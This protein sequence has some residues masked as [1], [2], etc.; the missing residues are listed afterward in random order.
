MS[1]SRSAFL[2]RVTAP[3]VL[4]PA[5]VVGFWPVWRWYVAR[6]S[7]GSDEPLGLLALVAAVVFLPRQGWQ[8]GRSALWLGT[9][10]ATLAVYVATLAIAP[11]LIR[12]AL[13][14][15]VVVCVLPTERGRSRAPLFSLLLLSLPVIASLQYYL[16]YPLR[17]LTAWCCAHV[18]GVAGLAVESRGTVLTWTG[19]D[20]LLDAP[21]SGIR[22]LWMAAFLSATLAAGQ[23][24]GAWSCVRLLQISAALVFVANLAR[25]VVLFFLET[26]LWPNPA[27]AHEAVG[28]AAFALVV[29]GCW[30][31]SRRLRKPAARC[32][33][34]HDVVGFPAGVAG[35]VLVLLA[36]VAAARPAWAVAAAPATVA[37]N[38][39]W[40]ASFEERPLEPATLHPFERK[41]AR[42]FPGAIAAFT[43]GER[44]IVFRQIQQATRK[45]HPIADC[46]RASGFTVRAVAAQRDQDGNLWAALEARGP[47][48]KLA[49]RER[50]TDSRGHAWT[51]ASAWYWAAL[52]HPRD[53]PWLSVTVLAPT[54]RR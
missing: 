13:A 49:V 28:L 21:C 25:S 43:D 8:T 37:S 5:L 35:V 48:T 36:A 54:A 32:H 3:A 40:P 38:P 10:A 15:S 11:A 26:G 39:E 2:H 45:V 42:D 30:W 9:A 46:L 44:R 31:A 53:G 41:L 29:A 33:V 1:V 24:M 18:L 4:A 19:G 12:A 27:G 50:F 17:A 47:A 51:E 22:M 16:G 14:V 34:A 7:D 6:M 20:V 52:L 23:R